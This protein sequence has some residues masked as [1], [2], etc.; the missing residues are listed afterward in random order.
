VIPVDG[1]TID[2]SGA[3]E[4]NLDVDVIRAAA[5]AAQI[6]I[7]EVP[8]TSSAYADV[9]NRI[10]ADG[11]TDI[12]STSWGQCALNLEPSEIRADT[13]AINAARRVGLSIFAAS[14]DQ[15]AYDCQDASL[16]DHRL[17]VDWPAASDGIIGVGGTR[18]YVNADGSYLREAAWEYALS[19]AGG[20][21]GLAAGIPRPSW[22]SGPGVANPYS[23]GTRQVPDVSADAD[24]GTGWLTYSSGSSGGTGS[25]QEA[26]GTSAAAPF[27]A[28]SMLLTRQYAHEHGVGRLGYVNPVLYALA[29]TRQAFA[30]FHDVT[31]GGNRYYQATPGWDAATGLGSPDVYNLA[32]DMS[33]YLRAHPAR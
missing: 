29:S 6:L 27:W 13:Q 16:S 32:R 3:D 18:L 15:G 4:V 5:P 31:E 19:N 11:S 17:S 2:T 7:Y 25:D 22:Q 24:P 12:V 23:N 28:A 21:G 20:G 33:T 10:V 30:P 14:G 1:G 9:I 8:Q 26:G